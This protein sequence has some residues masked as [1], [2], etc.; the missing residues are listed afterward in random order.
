MSDINELFQRDPLSLTKDDLD[1]IIARFRQARTQFNLAGPAKAVE[2]T[3]K[4]KKEKLTSLD[5]DILDI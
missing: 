2:K 5:I 4:V 3:P 1:Q